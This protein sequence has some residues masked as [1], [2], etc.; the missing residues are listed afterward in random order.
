MAVAP[1]NNVASV[2]SQCTDW[3]RRSERWFE[4]SGYEA[5]TAASRQEGAAGRPRKRQEGWCRRDHETRTAASRQEGI[6]GGPRS[7]RKAGA[8]EITERGRPLRGKKALQEGR[9]AAGRLRKTDHETRTAAL[10]QEGTAG[11]PRKRQEGSRRS[12]RG[13]QG[14]LGKRRFGYSAWLFEILSGLRSLPGNALPA[15]ALLRSCRPHRRSCAAVRSSN[16]P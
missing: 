16:Q 3:M 1:V 12:E 2:S 10:R 8:G 7:G 13:K 15:S 9:A 5:T 4:S 11:R 14:A 6:A